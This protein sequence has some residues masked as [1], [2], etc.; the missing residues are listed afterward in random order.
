MSH[1]AL[2]L[3]GITKRYRSNTVLG[4]IDLSLEEGRIYGLIGENGAGKSTLIRIVMGLSKPTSGTVELIGQRGSAGLR[5]ARSNIGYVPDSSASYPLLSAADNLKARCLEWGLIALLGQPRM[6]VLDEPTNGL[7][8]LG[9]IEIRAHQ[10]TQPRARYHGAYIEPQPR[11]ASSDGDRLRHPKRWQAHGRADRRRCRSVER[12]QSG[13]ALCAHHDGPSQ[14]AVSRRG[15]PA[16]PQTPLETHL[17]IG[18]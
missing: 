16:A 5:N 11:R 12:R 17:D 7:D 1:A 3:V 9:T 2:R 18:R 8:P 4:P 10:A 14:Q 6:L 15:G 13:E